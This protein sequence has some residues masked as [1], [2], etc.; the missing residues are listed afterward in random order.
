M[1]EA[2]LKKL[3]VPARQVMMDVTMAEVSLKDEIDF[4]IDWLFKGGAPSG[5][6]SGG[7]LVSNARRRSTR[8]CRRRRPARATATTS[9]VLA[10]AQ[11]LH[12]HHQ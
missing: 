8:R 12:L 11:G 1:I 4:G 7:L 6:G 9:A 5:R 2:A 3:D 10:L